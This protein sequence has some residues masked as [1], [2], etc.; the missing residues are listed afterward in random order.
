MIR[1]QIGMHIRSDMVVVNGTPGAIPPRN[2]NRQ[3][4]N[5]SFMTN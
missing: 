1:T 2:N 3:D 5:D 4:T